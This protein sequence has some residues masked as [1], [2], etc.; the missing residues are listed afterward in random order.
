MAIFSSAFAQVSGSTAASA[1]PNAIMN[2]LPLL[3]IF[4]V[5]YFF[6][7]RPQQKKLKEHETLV[8]SVKRGDEIITGG[9]ILG[10]IS[11]IEEGSNIVFVEIAEGVIVRVNK[12]T[13]IDVAKS[14][15]PAEKD[16]TKS[17]PKEKA[18]KPK[19]AKQ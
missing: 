17:S 5:F 4:A 8:N 19:K 7:I 1:E 11:K 15:A 12:A 6:L 14:S 9:G 3:L 16:L 10:K 18:T 2:L 13:I